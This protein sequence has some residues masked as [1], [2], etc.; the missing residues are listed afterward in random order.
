MISPRSHFTNSKPSIGTVEA[1]RHFV[2]AARSSDIDDQAAM[3][4]G[5]E[6]SYIQCENGSFEAAVD[7][8]MLPNSTLFRKSTNR[9][10]QKRFAPPP[11]ETALAILL[12][13]SDPAIFQGRPVEPGDILFMPGGREHELICHGAFN[14]VVATFSNGGEYSTTACNGFGTAHPGVVRGIRAAPLGEWLERVLHESLG[15]SGAGVVIDLGEIQ[16]AMARK[17]AELVCIR[18]QVSQDVKPYERVRATQIFATLREYVINHLKLHDEIPTLALVVKELGVSIRTL[19]YTCKS[20]LNVSP[21]RYLTCWRL[22]CARRDIRARAGS[23]SVTDI[24]LK[25]GFSHLGR[26]SIA[27]RELFGERPSRTFAVSKVGMV[28]R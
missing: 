11:N 15:A 25:W 14:T 23:S 12:S 28:I 9:K 16:D 18:D 17:C 1:A 21:Q 24:A 8:L 6:Q 20:L 19:E 2:H 3:L 10:L 22:H 27:Y 5:W 26:F 4:A 7:A 13:G